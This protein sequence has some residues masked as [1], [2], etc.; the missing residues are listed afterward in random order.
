MGLISKISNLSEVQGL[1]INEEEYSRVQNWLNAYRGD[2]DWQHYTWMD[3]YGVDHSEKRMTLNMP[4]TVAHEMA[5]LVFN[6]KCLINVTPKTDK[7]KDK[8]A[9][10]DLDNPAHLFVQQ[11]LEDNYFYHNAQRYLEYMFATGGM[12]IRGYVRDGKVKL[13][14]ATADAFIPISEDANGVTECVIVDA[15]KKSGAY[16]TFLEWHL[17]EDENYVIKNELYKSTNSDGSDIGIKVKLD[18][19]YKGLK[20]ETRYSKSQYTVPTF[21][22]VKPNIANN[23][24]LTSPMGIPLIAN[25]SDTLKQLDLLYDMLFQENEMGRRRVNIPSSMVKL[26]LNQETGEMKR[27]VDWRDRAY[28][29][30]KSDGVENAK[31]DDITLPLRDDQMLGAINGLLNILAGQTG[32]SAG[33]FTMVQ[34][35]EMKT[36][37]EVISENSKTHKSKETHETLIGDALKRVVQMVVELGKNSSSEYEG[38][39]DINVSINFDDSVAKDR[40]QDLDYYMQATNNQQLM[41]L[42]E[43]VKRFNG[44]TDAEA[45]DYVQ[46]IKEENADE[47]D[48]EDVLGNEEVDDN[49]DTGAIKPKNAK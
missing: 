36:A 21:V 35:G 38:P 46:R 27:Q 15:F 12:V 8:T 42:V 28:Q 40:N 48:I 37:T 5:S 18:E 16:Y 4:K 30:Y 33:T 47:G 22:Y 23:I 2:A 41:P 24:N 17:E 25:A 26:K 29:V 10:E 49:A 1:M 45:E 7:T 34:S 19:V 39:T 11:V 32:F 13:R 43:A 6:N 3:N 9:P 44:I 31:P 20:D 14:F